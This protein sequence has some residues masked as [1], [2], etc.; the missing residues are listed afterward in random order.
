MVMES[1]VY[2]KGNVMG[3][4]VLGVTDNKAMTRE[5]LLL[6]A[7][8]TTAMMQPINPKMLLVFFGLLTRPWLEKGGAITKFSPARF[9]G[10][11]VL[12]KL[13]Y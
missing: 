13:F 5:E 12:Q 6:V 2:S 1:V 3:D 11:L 9:Y 4:F 8:L 7:K 10:K